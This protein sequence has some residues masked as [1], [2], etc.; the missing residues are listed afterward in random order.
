[1][2]DTG[3]GTEGGP[4]WDRPGERKKFLEQLGIGLGIMPRRQG[5]LVLVVL[6]FDFIVFGYG[7]AL[8]LN[9][10]ERREMALL[11]ALVAAA[12]VLVEIVAVVRLARWV[13]RG[14]PQL[15]PTV[16]LL[17]L[18]KG[19]G[20]GAVLMLAVSLAQVLA[21]N[22]VA[23]QWYFLV[24]GCF[25]GAFWAFFAITAAT[26]EQGPGAPGGAEQ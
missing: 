2:K 23:M 25:L 15:P 18:A 16:E 19:I 26:G 1:M 21:G 17:A 13:G 8:M 12:A 11:G 10:P 3:D 24:I 5:K 20:V 4:R 22:P 6:S 14:C 9:S 7:L